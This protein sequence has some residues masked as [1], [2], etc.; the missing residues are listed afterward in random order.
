MRL[1]IVESPTKAVAISGYLKG[2]ENGP[3]K[4]IASYGHV[5]ALAKKSGSIDV[6][7]DFK[8]KWEDVSTASEVIK[9]IVDE[10]KKSKEVILATDPDR[11]GEAISWHIVQIL[12]ENKVDVKFSRMVFNSITPNEVKNAL[13]NLRSIN[14]ELVSAYKARK[15][16]D[17]LVG[18]NLSPVLWKKL[19]CRSNQKVQS[20]GRVQSAALRIIVERENEIVNFESKPYWTISGDFVQET[21]SFEAD[22]DY[23]NNEKIE[24]FSWTEDSV[25]A[26]KEVLEKEEYSVSKIDKTEQ[27]RNPLAPFITSTMQQEAASRLDWKPYETMRVAQKLYEGVKVGSAVIG[28]ITYMRT[29]SVKIS[30]QGIKECRDFISDSFGN[31]YVS[32]SVNQYK[33]RAKNAQEAHEAI[34]PTK[35]DFTPEKVQDYLDEKSLKLYR[36]IWNRSVASQMSHALYDKMTINIE[37]KSSAWKSTGS[38]LKFDGY[39]KVYGK[40]ESEEQVIWNCKEGSVSCDEVNINQHETKP[41]NRFTETGIIKYLEE[42]GIGR[43]STYANI[44]ST[45]EYRGYVTKNRKTL[46][47]SE[48]GWL[49]TGFLKNNFEKFIENDFTSD[50]EEK[51]D[52]IANGKQDLHELLETFWKDFEKYIE[53]TDD[54]DPKSVMLDISSTYTKFFF[55]QDEIPNCPKC[56]DGKQELKVGKGSAFLS[57]SNY[58]DCNWSKSASSKIDSDMI[59]GDDPKTGLP[60][61]LKYGP[62]GYYLQIG[63]KSDTDF[64]RIALPK[65]MKDPGNMNLENALK[66]VNSD[67]VLGDDPETGLKINLKHGPYGYYIQ[68][69]EKSDEGFKRIPV[70]K[71][72]RNPE[73]ITFEEAIK[74]RS[75]PL[76]M[77]EYNDHDVH[78][79]IGRFGPHLL[80]NNVYISIKKRNPFEVTWDDCL[81]I[82]ESPESKKKIDQKSKEKPKKPR[83]S[84]KK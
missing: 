6:E 55:D 72:F 16:L 68:I 46:I 19:P 70:P 50:M 1:I 18:F 80:Y 11:E 37:S 58:P 5:R 45:L 76:K 62:Y 83:K 79:D 24:K 49:V 36:L 69:G 71:I 51:L 31:N 27:K 48:I 66:I 22:L 28:L 59:L 21:N 14:D 64:K 39:Q 56:S 57:C 81:E 10:A 78:V 74:I 15:A 52:S 82:L 33:S 25:K 26:A 44:L 7:K 29:D 75:L 20:A 84:Y 40:E 12:R 60:I 9:K 43:P 23:Y 67:S 38:K 42:H 61:A 53:K 63:Q 32:K 65:N 47:P 77:G 3:Y 35:F 34:R 2:F 13:K 73:N 4:V 41:P 8:M 54:L 17:Y 30:D